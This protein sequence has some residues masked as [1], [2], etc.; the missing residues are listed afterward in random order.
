[1]RFLLKFVDSCSPDW[2]AGTRAKQQAIK[3]SGAMVLEIVLAPLGRA[4]LRWRHVLP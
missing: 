3:Q 4:D 1:M 2:D